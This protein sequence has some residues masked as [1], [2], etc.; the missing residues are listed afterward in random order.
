MDRHVAEG[1]RSRIQKWIPLRSGS[2]LG[3]IFLALLLLT[4]GVLALFSHYVLR[5]YQDQY[6]YQTIQSEFAH[7]E[8]QADLL[9]M[10]LGRLLEQVDGLKHRE[11]CSRLMVMEDIAQSTLSMDVAMYLSSLVQS[12]GDILREIWIYFDQSKMVLSSDQELL[13]LTESRQQELLTYYEQRKEAGELAWVNQAALLTQNGG[14]YL[15]VGYPSSSPLAT[16][17]LE[18]DA[19]ALLAEMET[20]WPEEDISYVYTVFGT[21][22]FDRQIEYPDPQTLQV[23][24]EAEDLWGESC[25]AYSSASAPTDMVLAYWAPGTDLLL[26][27][28]IDGRDL[29]PIRGGWVQ[30]LIP[31]VLL[32]AALMLAASL[33][34]YRRIYL[35]LRRVM[36]SLEAGRSRDQV[37]T[38]RRL[39]DNELVLVQNMVE[40]DRRQRETMQTMLDQLQESVREKHLLSLFRDELSKE[41]LDKLEKDG[42]L[43]AGDGAYAVVYLDW[44]QPSDSSGE[45][46]ETV[47]L[48]VRLVL[49]V[50]EG[51]KQ[52]GIVRRVKVSAAQTAWLVELSSAESGFMEQFRQLRRRAER[53]VETTDFRCALGSAGP[54]IGLDAVGQMYEQARWEAQHWSYY[55]QEVNRP[56]QKDDGMREQITRA[57]R[58]TIGQA[59]GSGTD[60]DRLIDDLIRCDG[61]RTGRGLQLLMDL[62]MEQLIQHQ[63]DPEEG[64]QQLRHALGSPDNRVEEGDPR[65][66]SVKQFVQLSTARLRAKTQNRQYQH[67][68]RAQ[69]Y[70]A[71]HFG[72]PG[73]SLEA[74]SEQIGTTGPY[75]S[76]L[77]STRLSCGFL[78]YLNRYRITQA[79]KLLDATDL[80]VAEIGLKCGF[81]SPQAFIRVFKKYVGRTPGQY[82]NSRGEEHK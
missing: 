19:E 36:G 78:D 4:A 20:N 81:N 73:L 67:I 79:R 32:A 70:L 62:L 57:L 42:Q 43:P 68:V 27:T 51:C 37:A 64:W 60:W 77:F 63:I 16:I 61:E 6:R 56:S 30:A 11:D 44:Q 49:L 13:P 8:Y 74:V 3:S 24:N 25:Y 48:G 26:V 7:M 21:P 1:W 23:G 15:A 18:L 76:H 75:L 33:W 82:R 72:D 46:T 5:T 40:D 12:Y 55:R 9:Q 17:V 65:L 34:M 66:E 22:I 71:E 50:E 10:E 58:Q 28:C 39:G 53:V 31:Y 45:E 14:L 29:I 80:T 41:D 54:C 38:L 35:P 2:V 69:E 52:L 47:L 59:Q